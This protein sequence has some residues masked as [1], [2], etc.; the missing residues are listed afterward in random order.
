MRLGK[1][2][3]E[4]LNIL[5][6]WKNVSAEW[7]WKEGQGLG[8]LAE[9]DDIAE[10]E[11]GNTIPVWMLRRDIDCGKTVLSRSLKTLDEKGFI[12]LLDGCLDIPYSPLSKYTKYV[13]ITGKGLAKLSLFKVSF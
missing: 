12:I 7:E 10:Y 1:I 6:T 4:I 2:E 9:P 11:K 3:K 5:H 13:C 8:E